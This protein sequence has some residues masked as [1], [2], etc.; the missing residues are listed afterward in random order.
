MTLEED[1]SQWRSEANR[2]VRMNSGLSTPSTGPSRDETVFLHPQNRFRPES[3]IAHTLD[4]QLGGELQDLLSELRAVDEEYAGDTTLEVEV[5]LTVSR[6]REALEGRLLDWAKRF[7]N[8]RLGQTEV[9]SQS[10]TEMRDTVLSDYGSAIGYVASLERSLSYVFLYRVT[11]YIQWY[12]YSQTIRSQIWSLPDHEKSKM[13]EMPHM[14]ALESRLLE[15]FIETVRGTVTIRQSTLS[16]EDIRNELEEMANNLLEIRPFLVD[17]VTPEK[18]SIRLPDGRWLVWTWHVAVGMAVID[19]AETERHRSTVARTRFGI[20][21]VC[22]SYTGDLI[23][24]NQHWKTASSLDEKPATDMALLNLEIV[25]MFWEKL[26]GFYYKIDHEAIRRRRDGKPDEPVEDD[27]LAVAAHDLEEKLQKE[28]R[29][30]Q[31]RKLRLRQITQSNLFGILE[32]RFDCEVTSGKGSEVSVYRPGY[33][34]FTLG[35]HYA[36]PSVPLFRLKR[37]LKRL[38]IEPH[39]FCMVAFQK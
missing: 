22:L 8:R 4:S 35:R 33:R 34:I 15:G 5:Y 24:P 28:E 7:V 3:H 14:Q 10:R 27:E 21:P 19:V 9:E 12:I 37:V 11:A 2:I 38:G 29:P 39:E 26:L 17:S 20:S 25:R 1:R 23:D 30:R 36:R 31:D 16:N 13:L 32:S 18:T 6:E